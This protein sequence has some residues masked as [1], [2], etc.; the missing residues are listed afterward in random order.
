M[1]PH[2]YTFH[3]VYSHILNVTLTW[4]HFCFSTNNK[5]Y[6]IW[7]N[8]RNFKFHKY[9]IIIQMSFV[10]L[11]KSIVDLISLS[12]Q[13][14]LF[15][16]VMNIFI[17]FLCFLYWLKQHFIYLLHLYHFQFCFLNI[18]CISCFFWFKI[19]PIIVF[20][21]HYGCTWYKNIQSK[22]FL[23]LRN[24]K[25]RIQIIE[26]FCYYFNELANLSLI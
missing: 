10:Y 26:L 18:F 9:A 12:F 25:C 14:F 19:R 6:D 11:E 3:P 22:M 21:L 5:T 7:Q 24:W 15:H 23:Q 20:L 1:H 13:S 17:L 8:F 4:R 2:M 16:I